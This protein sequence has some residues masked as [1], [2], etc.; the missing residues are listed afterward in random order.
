MA[1]IFAE[2]KMCVAFVNATHIYFSAKIPV[3]KIFYL[4]EVNIL[5]TY[6]LVKLT[7][8]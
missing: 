4:I 1:Y 3:I 8:L 7:M 6:E 2:K 5:N